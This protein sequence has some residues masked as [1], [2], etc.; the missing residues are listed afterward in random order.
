MKTLFP[1]LAAASAAP[2]IRVPT[3]LADGTRFP[4][5]A[6]YSR[7]NSVSKPFGSDRILRFWEERVAA[8]P[9]D[10]LRRRAH[11]CVGWGI[12][13]GESGRLDQAIDRFTEAIS[14]D[15]RAI[16][17]HVNRALANSRLGDFGGAIA[18]F[19]TA[20]E[21]LEK[22]GDMAED[23]QKLLARLYWGRGS[24]CLWSDREDQGYT[25]FNKATELGI[26]MWVVDK[27]TG[28]A[29]ISPVPDDYLEYR[30]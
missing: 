18:D 25:D 22:A 30:S 19:D 10:R 11:A 20:I 24:A 4:D 17:A 29:R 8:I 2:G 12:A 28:T 14:V 13:Y 26:K 27:P 3:G 15:P 6:S 1:D 9:G 7:A 23:G 16:D 21:E 5:L